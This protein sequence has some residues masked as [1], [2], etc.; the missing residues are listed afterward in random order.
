M[1]L[2]FHSD[3]VELIL[4]CNSTT[5]TSLLFN[6]D[7]LGEIFPSCGLRQGDLISLYIFILCMEFLST[8]INLKC[9]EGSWKRIKASRNGPRFSHICFC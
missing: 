3:T 6:R 5:T 9:E 7:H 1:S 8:L 4:S 2:G